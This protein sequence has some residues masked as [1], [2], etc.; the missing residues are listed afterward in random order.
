MPTA[1]RWYLKGCEECGRDQQRNDEG[2][3]E[4]WQGGHILYTEDVSGYRTQ[5]PASLIDIPVAQWKGPAN[6]FRINWHTNGAVFKSNQE[7]EEALASAPTEEEG[8]DGEGDG[9]I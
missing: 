8:E 2:D 3:L 1:N 6:S 7:K 9:A 5:P 4:C